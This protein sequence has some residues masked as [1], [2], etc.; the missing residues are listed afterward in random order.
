MPP[1][2]IRLGRRHRAWTY[3][4][5]GLLFLS[6]AAWQILHWI[7]ES[8]P[9]QNNLG[10]WLMRLHGAAAMAALVILGTLIPLHLRRGWIARRNRVSGVAFTGACGV[11]VLTG[12]ALYY[13]GSESLRNWSSFTHV[14]V[15]L[16][17]P[18]ALLWHIWL[19]RKSRD[20]P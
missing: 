16:A 10:P 7:S 5:C 13:A 14:A 20:Q 8:A 6:G 12:Y 4:V 19:G 17:G 11:L 9:P 2:A 1:D 15:G 3:T 18:F